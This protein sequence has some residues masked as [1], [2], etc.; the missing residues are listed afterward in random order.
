MLVIP[1][2]LHAAMLAQAEAELPNECCGLLAG[3]IISDLG[4][5]EERYPL[6]NKLA[7]PIAYRSED[8]SMLDAMRDIDRR[9]LDWLAIYHSHPTSVPV[10]SRTDLAENIAANLVHIIVSLQA[11]PATM[12]AWWLSETDYREAQWRLDSG[13][14]APSCGPSATA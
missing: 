12:R 1:V 9:G 14:P 10:P 3:R 6:V 7:S 5:V 13:P 2:S 11:R 8:R 4:W